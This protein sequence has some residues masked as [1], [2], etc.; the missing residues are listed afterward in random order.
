MEPRDHTSV[1]EDA[2]R[3]YRAIRLIFLINEGEA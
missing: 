3:R 2:W 1:G